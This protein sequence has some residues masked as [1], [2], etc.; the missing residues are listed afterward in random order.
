MD[1][2]IDLY[3]ASD[4]AVPHRGILRSGGRTYPCAIGAAG[5]TADKREGDRKTPS[6]VYELRR[7]FYRPD[8]LAAVPETGLPVQ[9]LRPDD[10]WCD[11]AGHAAYNRLV[12]LPHAGRH[13]KLWRADH[14]YDL[15]IEVGYNDAPPMPGKGSAIFIHVAQPDYAGT[16]GC[17]ALAKDDFLTIIRDLGTGSSIYIGDDAAV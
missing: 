7:L 11:D 1:K 2:A 5:V 14:V 13:E 4:P 16:E 15:I 12:R 6:G 3:V 17:I 9:P 8:R 10:G